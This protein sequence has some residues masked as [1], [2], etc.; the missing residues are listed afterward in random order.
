MN[1]CTHTTHSYVFRPAGRNTAWLL[2]VLGIF[3]LLGGCS[4]TPKPSG[5]LVIV[6]GGLKDD[7]AAIFTRFVELCADGPIGIVPTASG[8]G[9]EAGESS[10]ARWRKWAGTR[11]VVV[12]PLTQFDA[13]KA[14]DPA[15]IQ[16]IDSCG[17]LWFTGGDQSRIVAVFR[18][19]G[20]DTPAMHAVRRVLDKGGVVGGTSAGAAMMSDPMITGGRSRS[21]KSTDPEN[22]D[23]RRVRTGPGLGLFTLGLTD[24]HFLERGRMGRLI[25]AM[26]DTGIKMGFGVSENCGMVVQLRSADCAAIGDR[27]VCIVDARAA[28]AF[29]PESSTVLLSV[30]SS[31]DRANART[32]SVYPDDT[33]LAQTEW[34]TS[35]DQRDVQDIWAMKTFVNALDRVSG[36]ATAAVHLRDARAELTLSSDTK[37]NILVDRKNRR[38]RCWEFLRLTVTDLPKPAASK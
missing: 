30:L 33:L 4:S 28:D 3:V 36:E 32:G 6:G 17:G 5:H 23:D 9:L 24:Q 38:P 34:T 10:A 12:I 21:G 2:I 29:T 27:A 20:Q 35:R 13:A 18:P 31:G 15:I 19:D 25:D 7:N 1:P 16:Q 22:Q 37:T 8:D 11:E 26:R 14:S